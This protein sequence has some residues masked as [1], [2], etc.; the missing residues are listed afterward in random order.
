MKRL[1]L[2]LL[3]ILASPAFA[4]ADLVAPLVKG[5]TQ[6]L[7]VQF[8]KMPPLHA[9][10][11]PVGMLP[12]YRPLSL[13]IPWLNSGYVWCHHL[14]S[15]GPQDN[16][17]WPAQSPSPSWTGI[18]HAHVVPN[19][20][21]W[22]RL[23]A[24]V[25]PYRIETANI[26]GY[27][28]AIT[29]RPMPADWKKTATYVDDQPADFISGA[30]QTWPYA[31]TYGFFSAHVKFEMDVK[32]KDGKF[33]ARGRGL[34]QA[35]YMLPYDSTGSDEIDIAEMADPA[36]KKLVM[37][38]HAAGAPAPAV[39]E[40]KTSLCDTD[41]FVSLDWGPDWMIFY[42]DNIQTWKVKTPASM[43]RP[44]YLVVDNEVH[45]PGQWTGA[46]ANDNLPLSPFRVLSVR[47]WGAKR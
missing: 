21:L 8:N 7:N 13:D 22:V 18:N 46:P 16:R 6:T 15:T 29:A 3:L 1:L 28:L 42:L 35:V 39:Y 10:D 11:L 23:P 38:L 36:C 37:T 27:D 12:S 24:S 20:D 44:F 30:I 19:A 17:P 45:K 41:H 31:Q 14:Y 5:R 2:S 33:V 26:W 25:N 9:G 47:A 40:S 43:N 4:G 32:G 34:D